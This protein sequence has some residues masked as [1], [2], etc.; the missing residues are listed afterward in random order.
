[1][2]DEFPIR[3]REVLA[4]RVGYRCSN[5]RCR[6]TTSGPGA[7]PARAI[8]IGVAAHITAASQDGPRYDSSLTSE[9]RKAP[10]NGIWLCQSCSR[11]IDT[12]D[13]HYPI[14]KLT[15]WKR[16]AEARA[17]DELEGIPEGRRA[18]SLF[19]ML[20]PVLILLLCALSFDSSPQAARSQKTPSI[21]ILPFKNTCLKH[22]YLAAALPD[23]ISDRLVSLQGLRVV[24]AATSQAEAQDL[25]RL[26][27]R[28]VDYIL[29][30]R[31]RCDGDGRA[32]RIVLRLVRTA[33]GTALEAEGM[34]SIDQMLATT[35]E[36]AESATDW[37]MSLRPDGRLPV[38]SPTT[39]PEAYQAYLRGLA[40]N[41]M[42]KK[43]AEQQVRWFEVA[44]S[45]DPHF[46][47]AY[48]RLSQAN[49][50]MYENGYDRTEGRLQRARQAFERSLEIDP[51]QSQ[52]HLAKGYY[53]FVQGAYELALEELRATSRELP[54]KR[55]LIRLMQG[56]AEWSLGRPDE[57]LR[58]LQD[59][60]AL[61]PE[62]P[63]LLWNLGNLYR[64]LRRFEEAD[65]CYR[66]ANAVI[67]DVPIFHLA[68]SMNHLRW[69]GSAAGARS[70]L[71]QGLDWSGQDATLYLFRLDMLE[72][73][74]PDA[75]RRL[76]G[77]D[78]PA[79]EI[80]TV[81]APRD[82]L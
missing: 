64:E 16:R 79:L 71:P 54:N 47:L 57:A 10:E 59:A 18:F 55:V 19:R 27:K 12:D 43:D 61:D 39:N 31:V 29:Q 50:A 62:N 60:S 77:T 22:E 13:V 4:K 8:S 44:V 45:K 37:L 49:T 75:L 33:N 53:L 74:Y 72:R 36:I 41:W 42:D 48:A 70:L 11:L 14:D 58:H 7:D 1:M 67:P 46:A 69:R 66:T 25:D 56:F 68:R 9:V 32:I 20:T 38:S 78:E 2:R 26:K 52:G 73:K 40:S 81:F 21:V 34:T 28:G 15:E 80:D 6:K 82:Y 24:P 23:E 65:R 76:D 5:P 51:R 35:H 3:A 30:G 63:S 17:L